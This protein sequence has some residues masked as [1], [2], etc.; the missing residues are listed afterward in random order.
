M[1]KIV[2]IL[3]LTALAIFMAGLALDVSA[4]K[5][6]TGTAALEA[7]LETPPLMYAGIRG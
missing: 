1:G 7:T 2:A 4:L 6:L 5:T 3:A